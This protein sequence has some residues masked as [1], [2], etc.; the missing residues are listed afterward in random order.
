LILVQLLR[1]ELISSIM[2]KA[3][4]FHQKEK[5]VTE[6]DKIRR[7]ALIF[8]LLTIVLV[9][10]I[11]IWG[12][13]LFISL[14]DFLGE[15][16]SENER[17]ANEDVIPPPVPLF[18]TIPEAT[19]SGQLELK[20]VSESEAQIKIN[21]N[22]EVIETNADEEGEFN[23]EKL[24]LDEGNNELIAWAVDSADNESERTERFEIIYDTESPE[25]EIIKPEDGAAL[26][27]Q[28]IEVQGRTEPK[29]R[30]L[31]NEHVAIV[32]QEGEFSDSV[33][34]QEGG[35]KIEIIVTDKAGNQTDKTLSV[36]YLP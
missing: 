23:L 20:G 21:L 10:V 24:M 11:A 4:Q 29:A 35:N 8:G 7:R 12:I 16:K 5:P 25:L 33:I 30:V 14:V 17:I 9:A 19:N 1:A 34:L 13:P 28:T 3:N 22:G 31:V 36:T 15:T 26:E 32:D 6:E 27:E 2:T 18:N